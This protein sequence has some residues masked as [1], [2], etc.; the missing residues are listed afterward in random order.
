MPDVVVCLSYNRSLIDP[1]HRLTG[2]YLEQLTKELSARK[3][4]QSISFLDEANEWTRFNLSLVET[5]RA[6]FAFLSAST[7]NTAEGSSF[8][9]TQTKYLR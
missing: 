4:F 5:S 9:L 3:V 6:R 1:N 8:F 7:V 2:N